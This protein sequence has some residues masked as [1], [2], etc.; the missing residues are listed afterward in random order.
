[1]LHVSQ[2][3]EAGVAV[4][5]RQLVADQVRR[6]YT[7]DVAC[8]PEGRL[9]GWVQD[10][11]ARHYP[12]PA[13]RSPGPGTA[14]ETARLSRLAG[15]TRPD[16]VHLHSSKAGLA[17]RLALRGRTPTVFAPH[18]WSFFVGGAVGWAAVRWERLGARWCDV[19]LCVSAAEKRVGE[20]AGI[21][22][23]FAVIPNAVDLGSAAEGTDDDR[24][25]ARARLGIGSGPIAVCV[26]RLSRQKGQDVLLRAW[27]KVTAKVPDA[28]LVLV[29]DGPERESLGSL[30]VDGV[31]L[32]GFRDDVPEW[33]A[34]ANVVVLPSRWE[35]MS[36]VMLEAMAHGRSVVA[37]EVPGA[38]EVLGESAGEVV[39]VE[40]EGTLAVSIAERLRDPGLA[41]AEG[42]AGRAIIAERHDAGRVIGQTASL[43]ESLLEARAAST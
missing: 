7:V 19:I 31:D 25:A 14:V 3:T 38:R 22:A 23:R 24:R 28:R 20:Q 36:E 1:M 35:G 41:A 32:V 13:G 8:P 17:G 43:Y 10:E 26:G 9:G 27:P 18:A 4:C 16:I 2:P 6:G 11:G 39:A 34:A 37:T 5:V 15:A 33:L 12:W 21:R 30:H 29:G 40:D 42:A